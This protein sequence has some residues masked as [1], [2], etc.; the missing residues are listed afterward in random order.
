MDSQKNNNRQLLVAALV[1]TLATTGCY[2]SQNNVRVVPVQTDRPVSLSDQ[3]VDGQ[4]NVVVAQ[5]YE[6]I[7]TL[8]FKRQVE[9]P[10]HDTTEVTLDLTPELNKAITDAQGDAITNFRI[11]ASQ[12]DT[13]SHGSAFA[14]KMTG[15]IIGITGAT[16]L[17]TGAAVGPSDGLMTGGGIVMGTGL[18]SWLIGA[19][20]NEPTRWDFEVSGDIV[21]RSSTVRHVESAEGTAGGVCYP[22]HT[23][24]EGLAC[25]EA[26]GRCM[27]SRGRGESGGAC[28]PNRTCNAGLVC[29]AGVMRCVPAQ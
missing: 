28:Y 1:A 26:S 2:T 18:V 27:E 7:T 25:D 17:A 11:Q 23:C 3:Y 20:S 5:Q 13:G 24:N 16:L 10:R 12:Y 22:N 19:S 29:D 8:A 6:P 21:R 15:W 14:W 9:A 4:G